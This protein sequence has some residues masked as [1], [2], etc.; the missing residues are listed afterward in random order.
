MRSVLLSFTRRP[1]AATGLTAFLVTVLSAC[2]SSHASAEIAWETDLQAAHATAMSQSKPLL[3]HFTSDNCVWCDRL[4]AG[5]FQSP[6]VQQAIA[7]DFIPVKIHASVPGASDLA[8]MFKVTGFPYDV[9]VWPTG[10]TLSYSVSKQKPSDYVAMLAA[11]KAR[12]PAQPTSPATTPAVTAPDPSAMPAPATPPSQ[13][14]MQYVAATT[15]ATK[16]A[17]AMPGGASAQLAGART[18]GMSLGAP[19]GADDGTMAVPQSQHAAPTDAS[20][21][22]IADT[23]ST[24]TQPKLAMEGFCSVTVIDEAR[25]AEGNPKFGVIHLGQLFLFET[26][27]KMETFLADPVPYTPVLNG[28]DIVRFFEERRVVPGQRRF[29]V[30]DPV[31]GRMFFFADEAALNHFDREYQRYVDAAIAVMDKAVAAANP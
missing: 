16:P 2:L 15:P 22:T 3:L 14:P 20:P 25:W 4:E 26:K 28:I 6:E 17:G 5:A 27:A 18:D 31:H 21:P 23:A 7:E 1:L 19:T 13:A 24:T 12:I 8:K 10:Q 9:V 29:G 30:Q 11:S